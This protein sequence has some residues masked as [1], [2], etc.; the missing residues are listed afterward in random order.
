[1]RFV[2][3]CTVS[4]CV[5]IFIRFYCAEPSQTYYIESFKFCCAWWRRVNSLPRN[6]CVYVC[7]IYVYNKNTSIHT[8]ILQYTACGKMMAV[9]YLPY[10]HST[11]S[12]HVRDTSMKSKV[13]YL[14]IERARVCVCSA[15]LVQTSSYNRNATTIVR[16]NDICELEH[17]S[18]SGDTKTLFGNAEGGGGGLWSYNAMYTQNRP[19]K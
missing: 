5:W 10:F 16:F 8:L 3:I 9:S 1:M 18:G 13:S 12:S 4:V 19:W 11:V 17:S 14:T 2:R 15:V 7:K 6:I